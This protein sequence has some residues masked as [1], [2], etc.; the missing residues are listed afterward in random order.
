MRPVAPAPVAWGR[1][2]PRAVV[3]PAAQHQTRRA[4]AEVVERLA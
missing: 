2:H 1:C 4:V 3:A